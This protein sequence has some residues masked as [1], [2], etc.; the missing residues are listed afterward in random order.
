LL[1]SLASLGACTSLTPTSDPVYLRINDLEARLI[2]IERVLENESLIAL[3]T[4]ISSLRTEV[5]SLL[6]EVETLGFE[7]E[8]QGTRQRDLYV[9]LDQRLADIEAA[10]SRQG[11][12]PIGAAA[13]GAAV[14]DQQAYDAAFALVQQQSFPE[15]QAAFQSFLANYPASGSR[16][17]AHYWLGQTHYVQLAYAPALAEFQRVVNDFPE[18][19]KLTDSLLKI[20]ICSVNLGNPAAARQAFLRVIREFPGTQAATD[21]EQRLSQIP[22]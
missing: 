20:G 14:N 9:D 12:M 8:S 13:G 17:N 4:D 22:E 10:Q 6:G 16:A 2:R 1:T 11:S 5:Q 15:A 21:A 3:A 19:N 18:S 7:V